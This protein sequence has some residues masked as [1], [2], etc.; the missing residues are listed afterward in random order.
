MLNVDAAICRP[1]ALA[2]IGYN[3]GAVAHYYSVYRQYRPLVREQ[4]VKTRRELL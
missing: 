4:T 1:R 2:R 3:L